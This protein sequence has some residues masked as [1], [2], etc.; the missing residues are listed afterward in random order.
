MASFANIC[1]SSW[2]LSYM[3][4]ILSEGN[5]L[6]DLIMDDGSI[7]VHLSKFK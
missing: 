4:V 2:Y 6:I 7:T 5:W 1:V 3:L